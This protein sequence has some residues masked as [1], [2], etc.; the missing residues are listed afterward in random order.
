MRISGTTTVCGIVGDPIQHS[1]SPAMQ[2]AAFDHAGLDFVY[3]AWRL[4]RGAARSGA[5]AMKALGIRGLNVTVP[6]KVDIL[7]YLDSVDPRASRIGAVNTIVNDGGQLLGCNTDAVG[8]GQGIEAHGIH[9]Q[10]LEVVVL[11]AG[12]AARAVVF[13][14]L[15]S[16]A[17]VTILNRDVERAASLAHDAALLVGGPVVHDALTDASLESHVPRAALLVNTTSVGMHPLENVTPCPRRLLRRDLAV[18]DIVYTPRETELL[19][20]AALCGAVTVD[21]VEMLVRQGANAFEL[22][23]G[24]RAPVE[25][26]RE[27]VTRELGRGSH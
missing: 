2:N 25:L 4:P 23:T 6:H 24:I 5:D 13:W 27:V 1:L 14:L 15:D 3:V 26:M 17:R 16:G 22:W 19:R 7:P 9:V 11:G 20:D 12:G 8:F 18:C 21:G 10:G